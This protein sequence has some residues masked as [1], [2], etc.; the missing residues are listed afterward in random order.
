MILLKGV[1]MIKK[2]SLLI[3]T[4]WGLS[5]CAAYQQAASGYEA[6]ALKDIQS[7]EDNNIWLWHTN[8]CGTPLSAIIRHPEIVEG[9]KALCLS[10]AENPTTLLKP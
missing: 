3:L 2:I 9:L 6:A 5:G 8:A 1:D 7:A 4:V 10:G